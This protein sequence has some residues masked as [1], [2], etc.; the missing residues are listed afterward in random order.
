MRVEFEALAEPFYS[1][2][3]VRGH[4][5]QTGRVYGEIKHGGRSWKVD[6]FGVRDKSWGPR[7]WKSADTSA[8][9][10]PAS[11]LA[12]ARPFATW[13]SGNWGAGM[14]FGAGAGDDGKGNMRGGGWLQRDGKNVALRE[15]RVLDSTY[16]PGSILHTGMRLELEGEDGTALT[17]DGEVVGMCPTKIP[18]ASGATFVNEALAR[19]TCAGQTGWGIAEYWHSVGDEAS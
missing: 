2:E 13:F 11:G 8:K 3:G 5:E 16:R 14:A 17:L 15:V 19:F 6:G 4:F 10:E 12:A 18:Q 1:A 7:S 9:S